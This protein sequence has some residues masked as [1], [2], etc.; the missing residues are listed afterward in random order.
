M[1][2][3]VSISITY[4]DCPKSVKT[5]IIRGVLKISLAGANNSVPMTGLTPCIIIVYN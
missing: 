5:F 2:K 4:R 3:N 1:S